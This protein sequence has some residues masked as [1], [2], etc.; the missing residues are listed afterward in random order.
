MNIDRILVGF[1]SLISLYGKWKYFMNLG[2]ID[3]YNDENLQKY[4]H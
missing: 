1:G 2:G 4:I 3:D